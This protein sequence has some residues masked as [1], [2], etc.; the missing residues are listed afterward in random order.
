MNRVQHR[1]FLPM[2]PEEAGGQLDVILVTGDAYVDHNTYGV[3]L[4]GRWL[5]A[6]GYS[7]GVIAQPDWTDV[8]A[9]RKL[10]RPR[11]F[12]GVTS[13]NMDSCVNHFTASRRRRRDDAYSPGGQAGLRPDRASI[14]YSSMCKAA[15]PG[16]PVVLG[17]VE[18]SLR[19]FA[20]YDFWQDKIRQSILLD[21][22]AD[23][24]CHGMAEVS[25]LEIAD[26]LHAGKPIEACRDIPGTAWALGAKD[27][28]PEALFT[29][30]PSFEDVRADVAAFNKLT[31]LMYREANPECAEA[32]LQRHGRRAIWCNP[33]ARALTTAEMDRLYELPYANAPHPC[34]RE[35]IP[36]FEAIRGSITVNR[37]CAGGCS[38]CALTLHQGKDVVS[39]SKES[40]LREI[41]ALTQQPSFNG[42]IS[43]LGGPTANMF[44]MRCTSEAANKVCRRVSCLHPV[45]CKHYGT[46]HSA[47]KDLLREVRDLPGVKRVFVASGLRYDLAALD[48]DFVE[49]IAVHHTSGSLTTAPEHTSPRVLHAMRKPELGHFQDFVDRFKAASEDAG[50]KQILVP[51]FQCAHP[52]CGPQEAI[53]LGLYMKK[54]GLRCRQ[55]QT[56]MPT[57]GT[58][59]TAMYVS[60]RDPYTKADMPV[61][62]GDKERARQRAM[63]FW[64][65]REEWPAIREALIAWGRRDLIGRGPEHLV[66]PGPARGGWIDWRK[67]KEP[68]VGHM[69]LRADRIEYAS[70]AEQDE[71]RWEAINAC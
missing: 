33:P 14:P 34:Y 20:H 36:A 29:E 46:D 21:A 35:K 58:I 43:D 41:A 28:V 64:W 55:V 22:K 51:Y 71:E 26:R 11:L 3:A 19:R 30:A 60:E 54:N 10:G 12:F 49:E 57:P 24:L 45:R 59:S 68:T 2:T 8:E 13:G 25:I 18:A 27:A 52:G 70:R 53:E 15:F 23:L 62:K 1:P 7:V 56:F 42:V 39:R 40:V 50:K 63:M 31:V 32:L 38:F 66:P 9:F 67:G 5:E 44:H 47:Y 65:K 69:G 4:I 17:G 6:H 37:G 16:V 48:P 61:A